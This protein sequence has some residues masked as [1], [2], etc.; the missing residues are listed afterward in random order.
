MQVDAILKLELGR[1]D[2]GATSECGVSRQY[3]E[4]LDRLNRIDRMKFKPPFHPV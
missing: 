3:L 2:E 1:T 4:V